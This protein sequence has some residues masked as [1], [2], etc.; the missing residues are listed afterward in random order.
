MQ[1]DLMSEEEPNQELSTDQL[2]DV[3]GG[4]SGQVVNKSS[5]ISKKSN[6]KI[7]KPKN[8]SKNWNCDEW[9]K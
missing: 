5:Y 9:C 1:K 6:S 7:K 3:A 8:E 4:V 2:K